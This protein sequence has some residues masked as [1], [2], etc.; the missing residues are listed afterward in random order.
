MVNSIKCFTMFSEAT[1]T[2]IKKLFIT[3]LNANMASA[4]PT[5]RLKPDC[6]ESVI[7]EFMHFSRIRPFKTSEITGIKVIAL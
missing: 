3:N 6:R 1:Y 2:F 4:Q 5:P 7:S